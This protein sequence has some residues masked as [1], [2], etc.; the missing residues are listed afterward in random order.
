[1]LTI[2]GAGLMN[3]FPIPLPQRGLTRYAI[4]ALALATT[5]T[6]KDVDAGSV[7]LVDSGGGILILPDDRVRLGSGYLEEP[8]DDAVT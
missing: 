7:W 1:M 3:V 4:F 5:R 8:Q 2:L 6:T